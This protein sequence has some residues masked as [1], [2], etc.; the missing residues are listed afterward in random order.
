M[1]R[2]NTDWMMQWIWMLHFGAPPPRKKKK[3]IWLCWNLDWLYLKKWNVWEAFSACVHYKHCVLVTFWKEHLD[4]HNLWVMDSV[5]LSVHLSITTIISHR[6]LF[7]YSTM[8]FFTRWLVSAL[9]LAVQLSVRRIDILQLILR[10]C[11]NECTNGWRWY[12]DCLRQSS[13]IFLRVH[14]CKNWKEIPLR[15]NKTDTK[16]HSHTLHLFIFSSSAISS[17]F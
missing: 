1:R 5:C 14:I 15:L 9:T 13:A 6:V 10:G 11:N 12:W 4:V 3:K 8:L 17:Q 7:R 16:I 2:Q